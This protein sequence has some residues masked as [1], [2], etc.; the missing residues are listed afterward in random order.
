MVQPRLADAR[1]DNLS[2][3]A[4]GP[5]AGNAATLKSFWSSIPPLGPESWMYR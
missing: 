5:G 4:G 3:K 2:G 1:W